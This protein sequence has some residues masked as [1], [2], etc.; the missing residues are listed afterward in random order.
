MSLAAFP[1]GAPGV[2]D[3]SAAAAL[4]KA[5]TRCAGPVLIGAA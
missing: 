1:G 5:G 2:T 4:A 3:G